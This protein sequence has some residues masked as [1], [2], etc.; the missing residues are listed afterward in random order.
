MKVFAG[1][2]AYAAARSAGDAPLAVAIGNFDGVHLGH[3]ALLDEA[4]ARAA[5]RGGA[6][7]VLTF[8]P[9]PA[10]LFAP[11]KA[12]ALIMSLERRL[13]LCAEAGIDVAIVEAFTPAF[14]AIEAEAFVRRVL[15]QD[16]AARDVVVGYDFSFGRGRRGDVALL[17]ALGAELGIGVA[18]IPPVTVDGVPC[19]STRIRELC[20]AGEVRRAAALLGRPV[21]IVGR[22]VRGAARGKALGFPTANLAPEGELS[23]KLGIYAA[24]ARLLDGPDASAT[25]RAALSIG[26]NPTFTGEDGA[27]PVTVEA[28]L[29][30][31]DGDI[32]D[33]RLRL[34][35][36]DRLRDEQRFASVD[37]LVRQIDADVA[38]VRELLS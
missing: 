27:A 9:H 33:R 12:P 18:V 34:E 26:R 19:S 8:T 16:L 31:F 4:R 15:G 29:L 30:D 11:A 14:A 25:H 22:V 35:V 10:R 20:A 17:S 1:A 2:A 21:E 7:A 23:P 3:R 37:A 32:Y 24:R 38:R 6:S 36:V 28:Y 13:E 5:R